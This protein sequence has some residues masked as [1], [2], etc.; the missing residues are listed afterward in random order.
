VESSTRLGG[1]RALKKTPEA[2]HTTKV[3]YRKPSANQPRG[4]TRKFKNQV[5]RD[6][7]ALPSQ[8]QIAAGAQSAETRTQLNTHALLYI[9]YTAQRSKRPR[10]APSQTRCVETMKS[11]VTCV[12]L[13]KAAGS[14]GLTPHGLDRNLP[15]GPERLSG[16]FPVRTT[17]KRLPGQ[18]HE[19]GAVSFVT[20]RTALSTSYV[21]RA[22]RRPRAA[23]SAAAAPPARRRS[24]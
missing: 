16:F 1:F 6:S 19:V 2:P 21:Q 17:A 3:N 15:L 13:L 7:E 11:T 14:T 20:T 24:W 10:A 22:H 8:I 12:F 18:P 5:T 9:R 4:T 23:V